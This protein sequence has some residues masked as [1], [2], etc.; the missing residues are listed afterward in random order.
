[1]PPCS[2]ARGLLLVGILFTAAAVMGS[3]L[4]V[5]SESPAFSQDTLRIALVL[6]STLLVTFGA[7]ASRT[8]RMN[9]ASLSRMTSRTTFPG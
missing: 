8:T 7:T 2:W 5:Y 4:F 1:M 3:A 6:A 9:S